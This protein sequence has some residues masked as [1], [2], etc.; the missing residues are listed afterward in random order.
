MVVDHVEQFAQLFFGMHQMLA[1]NQTL[2]RLVERS[3]H[4]RK[5]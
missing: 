5:L 3:S 2:L 1:C 4:G